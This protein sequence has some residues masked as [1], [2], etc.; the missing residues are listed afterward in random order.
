MKFGQEKKV[1]AIIPELAGY[2]RR[3]NKDHCQP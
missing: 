3:Q 1:I 2:D